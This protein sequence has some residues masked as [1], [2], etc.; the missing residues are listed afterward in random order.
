MRSWS[1]SKPY[2]RSLEVSRRLL[3]MA[4][5]KNI[6]RRIVVANKVEDDEDLQV[7]RDYLGAEPDIVIPQD[8]AVL[9][10]DRV[11]ASPIDHDPRSPAVGALRALAS[12]LVT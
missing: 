11:G 6:G 12:S 3:E 2:P 5:A 8:S 4:V 7:I 9:A 10:A 1:S